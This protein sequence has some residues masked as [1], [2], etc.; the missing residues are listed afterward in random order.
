MDFLLDFMMGGVSAGIS[1]TIT[2]PIERVKLILQTQDS[3]AAIIASGNKYKGIG[4][5]FSRVAKEEGIPTLWRGNVANVIRY[6][7]TQAL[8]FA[9]K[10]QYKLLT[11][12]SKDAPLWQLFL[13][14]LMS[15]GAAGATSLT[16]VYPLDYVRTRLGADAGGARQFTGMGDCLSKTYKS[17]GIAGLY[18]GFGPSVIGIFFYRAAYFGLYDTAKPLIPN[19]VFIKFGV[20]QV[21]TSIAGIAAYPLDTIRR[22]MMM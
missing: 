4:D 2:A 18:R 1:K 10:E 5:C 11:P 17:D 19:N 6:F 7:P 15:G 14:N 16:F 22:R 21:V 3:N 8:N 20:A 12:R 13:G 9:F